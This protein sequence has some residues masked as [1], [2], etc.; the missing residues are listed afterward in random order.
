MKREVTIVMVIYFIIGLALVISQN[1]WFSFTKN[2]LSDMGSAKNPKGWMF[3]LYIIGLGII[4]IIVANLLN[5]NLLKI[6][7]I[8]LI[9]VGI[10]PEEEPPHTPSAILMYLLSFIDMGL[11]SRTWR[12]IATITFTIMVI[13][14]SFKI[15][16]AIPELIGAAAILSYILYLGWKR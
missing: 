2:A 7:M 3:N 14:V 16:L 8:L 12:I 5:R 4:G 9:L 13:L 6:S 1:P 15:G 11:Y 10:F